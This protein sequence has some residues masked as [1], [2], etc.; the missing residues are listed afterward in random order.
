M[1]NTTIITGQY[2]Q[3]SQTPAGLGERFLA[4]LIDLI[5]IAVYMIVTITSIAAIPSDLKE[6]PS[7]VILL[8]VL[9]LPV[10]GYSF[11][12]EL[13]NQGQSPGKKLMNIKV[14]M[15]DGSTP[16]LGAYLLRCLLFPIDVTITGGLG[17]LF[18]LLTKNNQRIG[19][20]AAGTMV[21][22][23]NNYKKVK[24][25]LDEY[26][27]LTNG[28]VPVY[29]QVMDL[30]LEQVSV[31]EKVLNMTDKKRETYIFELSRKLKKLLKIESQTE[32]ESFLKTLLQDYQYF[33]YVDI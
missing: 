21:V 28:Y 19:D 14:V 9:Y 32:D 31:I 22:R 29:P 11:L 16:T 23:M 20:L 12:F 10:L 33:A 1:A 15:T 3:I 18:V 13:F 24:V 5:I 26:K 25:S 7:L 8:L 27:H 6:G 17:V 4:F 2:V 30:S